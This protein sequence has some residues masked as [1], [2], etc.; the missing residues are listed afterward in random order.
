MGDDV[1]RNILEGTLIDDL[2]TDFVHSPILHLTKD[3]I[4]TQLPYAF[5]MQLLSQAQLSP[6]IFNVQTKDV[7]VIENISWSF[8]STL[9]NEATDLSSNQLNSPNVRYILLEDPDHFE[10]ISKMTQQNVH[11]IKHEEGK[12]TWLKTHG[13]LT[14]ITKLVNG[15][16]IIVPEEE[17]I[18]KYF[19]QHNSGMAICITGGSGAGKSSLLTRL[20]YQLQEK[21]KERVIIFLEIDKIF[22]TLLELP[23]SRDLKMFLY[24]KIARYISLN[25]LGGK[26]TLEILGNSGYNIELFIDGF[27]DRMVQL[28]HILVQSL[29]ALL[30]NSSNIRVI[31]TSTT[32]NIGNFAEQLNVPVLIYSVVPFTQNDQ[33]SFLANIWSNKFSIQGNEKMKL[34][35]EKCLFLVENE[36]TNS[37]SGNPFNLA[38]IA[39]L[40]ATQALK[41]VSN[42]KIPTQSLS[43]PSS[44]FAMYKQMAQLIFENKPELKIQCTFQVLKRICPQAIQRDKNLFELEE[45]DEHIKYLRSTFALHLVAELFVDVISQQKI[46]CHKGLSI[47]EVLKFTL[48]LDANKEFLRSDLCNLVNEFLI[49]KE[50]SQN[51]EILELL[52]YSLP[53]SSVT[54]IKNVALACIKSKYYALFC[55][56]SNCLIMP[57]TQTSGDL[58][59]DN[60]LS[61]S[62][63]FPEPASFLEIDNLTT[64]ILVAT[65]YGNFEFVKNICDHVEN[66]WEET[67]PNLN[68]T[69]WTYH[70]I[71]LSPIHVAAQ[72]GSYRIFQYFYLKYGHEVEKLKGLVHTTV[73]NTYNISNAVITEKIEILRFLLEKQDS[74]KLLAEKTD[75][76]PEPILVENIH[77]KLIQELIDQGSDLGT[78]KTKDFNT[79]AHNVSTYLHPNEYHDFVSNLIEKGD[80]AV[81]KEKNFSNESPVQI[82]LSNIQV[83]TPTIELLITKKAVEMD[84][85]NGHEQTMLHH[86]IKNGYPVDTIELAWQHSPGWREDKYETTLLHEAAQWGHYEATQ[87]FISTGA[88]INTKDKSGK[89]PLHLACAQKALHNVPLENNLKIVMELVE[90]GADVNAVDAFG[91]KPLSYVLD[92]E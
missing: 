2:L 76:L 9:T 26:L 23:S 84:S 56:L 35:A 89:T 67:V 4:P 16:K 5:P 28:Q 20:A 78:A 71:S 55:I 58:R 43:L 54:D 41:I 74:R 42:E 15:D 80:C 49:D 25:R 69:A 64:L 51:Q 65:R 82:A 12:Y 73:G 22:A 62:T 7:F 60:L 53:K 59:E 50:V 68:F 31:F 13:D 29:N 86:L 6:N 46:F 39:E 24:R 3:T 70:D 40:K 27:N 10:Q 17:L 52:K 32:N 79:I 92:S 57:V 88:C 21:Y 44:M 38:I 91:L 90:Q 47:P 36:K 85:E 1:F 14:E 8:L 48:E 83:E 11:Y 19:A 61:K 63:N 34:F 75:K 30:S 37:N 66:A 72:R 77:P 87:Y 81:L 45:M 33:I 18:D